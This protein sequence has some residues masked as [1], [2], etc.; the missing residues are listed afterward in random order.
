MIEIN[1]KEIIENL[2]DTFLSAGKVSLDLRKKGLSKEI[3]SDDF[4]YNWKNFFTNNDKLIGS[5]NNYKYKNLKRKIL[6]L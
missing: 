1:L 3:K 5:K 4:E 2:I 6:R